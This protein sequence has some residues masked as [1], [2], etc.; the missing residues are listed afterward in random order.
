[1]AKHVNVST[2]RRG[3]TLDVLLIRCT[4][5]HLVRNVAITD[6]GISDHS[7]IK[8]TISAV[9]CRAAL[10]KIK[11]RKLRAINADILRRGIPVFR[12]EDLES[13]SVDQLVNHYDATLVTLV[14][15]HAPLLEKNVRM[16]PD[17]A[18]YNDDL[19][20]AKRRRRRERTWRKSKL[21]VHK[22]T[23]REQCKLLNDMLL[24][25][26]TTFYSEKIGAIGK[27]QKKLFNRNNST[28]RPTH[29]SQ[30]KLAGRFAT[31]FAEKISRVRSELSRNT[32]LQLGHVL[33]NNNNNCTC[34]LS[35]FSLPTTEEIRKTIMDA[36]PKSC[37][38]VPAPTWLARESID[39]LLPILSRI[40]VQSLQ[41]SVVPDHYKT[42][43]ISPIIKKIGQNTE[44]V[45][46]YQP[47]SN[48]T[49]VS[50]VIECFVVKQL[51]D[52]MQDNYLPEQFQSAYRQHHSTETALIKV[53]CDI[54]SAV[55]RGCVVVLVMLE[56]TVAFDT[57][58]HTILL[59]RLTHRY[60][61][62]EKTE[63]FNTSRKM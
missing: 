2:H 32:V 1:M 46:N 42:G 54:M 47:V 37:Y 52:H 62:F 3:H 9:R 10:T 19:L 24:H 59:S 21:E 36:P 63:G 38:L 55:D 57:T 14:E 40:I 23:F 50:K 4:D 22:Q 15:T 49:F 53:H 16:R 45:Q 31:F 6:M 51:S 18:W 60:G 26:K 41:S 29:E 8:F 12:P 13:L 35:S 30:S 43:H 7:A 5:E 25:A 56:L 58:D 48:L 39:E 20:D 61:V 17:T 34:E 27:D 28:K 33:D 11:Y 44:L